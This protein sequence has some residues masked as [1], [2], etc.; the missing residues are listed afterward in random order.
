MIADKA[1][2]RFP[3]L[4]YHPISALK[5]I[6]SGQYFVLSVIFYNAKV[7]IEVLKVIKTVPISGILVESWSQ[8]D[9]NDRDIPDLRGN[10]HEIMLLKKAGSIDGSIQHLF[11]YHQQKIES[12]ATDRTYPL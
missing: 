11:K 8:N 5:L 4:H 10:Y 2:F 7:A 9:E 3:P 12:L 1:G 6:I